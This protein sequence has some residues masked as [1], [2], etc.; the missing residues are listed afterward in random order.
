MV[1]RVIGKSSLDPT[2]VETKDTT[3]V[4]VTKGH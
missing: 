3:L 4:S 2:T 1:E